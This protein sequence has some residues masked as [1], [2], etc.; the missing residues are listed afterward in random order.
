[1]CIKNKK[2]DK[3]KIRDIYS[4]LSIIVIVIGI[5]TISMFVHEGSHFFDVK[6]KY[7]VQSL[8]VWNLGYQQDSLGYVLVNVYD[9]EKVISSEFK[10]YFLQIIVIVVLTYIFIKSDFA[11]HVE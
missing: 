11:Q 1:M 8:C 6:D 5:M 3:M 4:V 9:S 10:A 7:E 2:K